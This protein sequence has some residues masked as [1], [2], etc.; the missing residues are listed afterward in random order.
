MGA[1]QSSTAGADF[2]T[3][4]EGLPD[5]VCDQIEAL[6]GKGEDRLLKPHLGA[7]PAFPTV[8]VGTTV[9]LSSA[10]A[11]A[12]L[13]VVPR[14]QRKH[15]EMIPKSM[16]EMDFWVSFF[17]H[18]TAVIEGNCPEKLEELASKASWQGSTTGD[19]PDSFTAAW[20]KLDQGKRDAVAALVARD[21]DAL[22]EPNS[23]SPPAFPKLPVGMECFIDRVAAT[24]AL[25][26]LPDL[27]KKHSM[28]VPKKLDERAFWV[29]F[30]TQMTV[31]I[32]DSKA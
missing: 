14:L 21:S 18:M 10:T 15:Y 5:D 27:Q 13:A 6:C 7:P 30:F 32:S 23:A 29:H 9:R 11:A 3:F 4:Y 22:L 20:S 28:L 26:A 25:T 16:P 17:S 1:E 12:A 31:A 8:P 2:T 24:A 19:A